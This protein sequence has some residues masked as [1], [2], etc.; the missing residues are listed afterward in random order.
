MVVGHLVQFGG[1]TETEVKEK[2]DRGKNPKTGRSWSQQDLM[3]EYAELLDADRLEDWLELFTEDC[4]YEILSRENVEQGL[5]NIMM[6]CDNRDMLL[7]R[8]DSYRHVNEYNLHWD[9][10]VIGLPL[11]L[12]QSQGL[13]R[14]EASCNH[15]TP[16]S[17]TTTWVS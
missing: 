8:I 7:D 10:H 2:K 14:I 13:W 9:R 1:A 16:Y 3:D 5:P 17:V 4:I 6:W 11:H 12:G 15:A